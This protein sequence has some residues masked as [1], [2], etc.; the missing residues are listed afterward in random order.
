MVKYSDDTN[1]EMIELENL[2]DLDKARI[3]QAQINSIDSANNCANITFSSECAELEG[4][5]VDA[6]KFFYH[7]ENSTGTK[8]DLANGH[9]AF[10]NNECV[11]CLWCPAS[12]SIDERFFIIGHVDIR[13]TAKCFNPEILYMILHGNAQTGDV[14]CLFDT[15][16]GDLLDIDNFVNIDESSPAKPI[17]PIGV[18]TNS[19]YS[20]LAYNF[21]V[22]ISYVVPAHTCTIRSPNNMY[23]ATATGASTTN[24]TGSTGFILSSANPVDCEEWFDA[25][26]GQ[27]STTA[28]RTFHNS[29]PDLYDIE[30]DQTCTFSMTDPYGSHSGLG[31]NYCDTCWGSTQYNNVRRMRSGSIPHNGMRIWDGVESVEYIVELSFENTFTDTNITT[32]ANGVFTAN[33]TKSIVSTFSANFND[34]VVSSPNFSISSSVE[35]S[36]QLNAWPSYEELSR[37]AVPLISEDGDIIYND[38][39]TSSLFMRPDI[40]DVIAATPNPLTMGTKGAYII[41]C[42]SVFYKKVVAAGELFKGYEGAYYIGPDKY[43]PTSVPAGRGNGFGTSWA[44][45]WYESVNGIETV[46]GETIPTGH[47][48]VFPCAVAS[49]YNSTFTGAAGTSVTDILNNANSSISSGLSRSV[50]AIYDFMSN[51]CNAVGMNAAA[52]Q[53]FY[54]A[55]ILGRISVMPMLK[56]VI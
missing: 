18:K 52:V 37:P 7:C 28:S 40:C 45:T 50:S 12:A 16:T 49:M 44:E 38:I 20:W 35:S 56:K 51:R 1:Y 43:I 32:L 30:G 4:I 34:I 24:Y 17:S 41:I 22:S 9:K 11:Y 27:F 21:E 15:S 3:V 13:G 39:S 23:S 42:G 29:Y 31:D 25:G 6:V 47:F 48:K 5:S 10:K 53:S 46:V 26:N 19:F 36:Y 14:Y 8:E 55:Y 33:A 54:D 2:F